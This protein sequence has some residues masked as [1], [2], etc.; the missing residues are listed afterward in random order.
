LSSVSE[1]EETGKPLLFQ[2]GKVQTMTRDIWY[3]YGDLANR[4][5]L[6]RW[7]RKIGRGLTHG[8]NRAAV[9]FVDWD[10]L[11]VGMTQAD[12]TGLLAATPMI[13][14]TVHGYNLDPDTR[15]RL[16]ELNVTVIRRLT[17]KMVTRLVCEALDTHAVVAC[18]L[19]Q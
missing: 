8:V 19:I 1:G 11:P 5:W 16:R 17:R 2:P 3:A 10:H 13:P 9:R 7:L 6:R 18:E 15:T 14:A 4:F 12:L